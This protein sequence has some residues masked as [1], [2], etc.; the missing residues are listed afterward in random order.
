[1][2]EQDKK[3]VNI[4][5]E[6]KLK[7]IEELKNLN[8]DPF[9]KR[10][11]KEQSIKEIIQKFDEI[12]TS[13][14]SEENVVAAGRIKALR[15]HGK[16]AFVDLEDQTGKVQIYV[17][18]NLVGSDLFEI[19][20]KI[21]VGDIIGVSGSIFKTRTGELTIIATTF[22]LLCKAIRTLPEKWHGL[23]DTEVRYRKRYLDLISNPEVR[24]VFIERSKIIKLIRDYLDN[25]GYLEVETP[26]L[27]PIPGGATAT[28]FVT[29]HLSLHRDLYLKI[30]PEL[31]LK[32]L[33]VG[34]IEKVY[35]LNRNFRNEGISTKHNP[36]F[37]MLELY[38]AYADY[39][40]MMNIAEEMIAFV[41][42][43]L[44]GKL[45]IEYQGE[46]IDFTPPWKRLTMNEAILSVTGINMEEVSNDELKNLVRRY[47]LEIPENSTRGNITNELFETEVEHTLIQPTFIM[48]YPVDVSPLSK[49]KPGSPNIVERFELFINSM[50]LANAFTELNDPVEQKRR[51][52]QQAEKKS[53]GEVNQNFVDYDY[54]EALEYGMPPAGGMGIGID[55]LVMLL[56]N[57][58]SI[59]EVILF[60]QLKKKE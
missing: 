43:K 19:F 52:I 5:R 20:K 45:V 44:K 47:K 55:R 33:L 36:E 28:P 40:V 12:A 48:D 38:E 30:A 50:E 3:N 26:V 1:M 41:L 49:Q 18:S 57:N 17:K 14:P 59:R 35:E 4:L 58:D 23:T 16:A 51:F 32:R 21:S 25:K 31:Y 39:Q 9:G 37:T 15:K 13:E 60:P 53:K 54:I 6:E 24:D 7:E 29:H 8:I 27:Q 2:T 22:T 46:K 11:E 10:F 42:K 56:T 34:G